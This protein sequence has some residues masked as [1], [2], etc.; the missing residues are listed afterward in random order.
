MI[1]EK[2]R[3]IEAGRRRER[4]FLEREVASIECFECSDKTDV[5]TNGQNTLYILSEKVNRRSRIRVITKSNYLTCQIS[6][7]ALNVSS[8]LV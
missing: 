5:Q 7:A 6:T 2:Q 1:I 4:R 3:K 8:I